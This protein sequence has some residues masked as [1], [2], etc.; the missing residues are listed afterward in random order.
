M[1]NY[2]QTEVT[3]TVTA[4]ST[5][6]SGALVVVGAIVGIAQADAASGDPVAL[7]TKGLFR[8]PK[9]SGFAG[10]AG[11]P[12]LYADGNER[13]ESAGGR[14]IGVYAA[15]AASADTE[16]IVLL[17]AQLGEGQTFVDKV[18]VV[19]QADATTTAL[20]EAPFGATISAISYFTDDA[21]SSA[22][23]TVLGSATKDGTTV[24]NA[25]TV[26]AELFT[27][28][29][30]TALTLTAVTADLVCAKGDLTLLKLVSNNADLVAGTGVTFFVAY[31]RA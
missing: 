25:A 2:V 9:Q 4:P 21:P 10:V 27:E 29:A 26:D 13:L 11:A 8:I 3:V 15:A 17:G 7:V 19:P 18:F 28:D 20:S 31:S 5:V 14:V 22:A 30:K 1:K 6:L 12:A 24:L 23:G 16:A